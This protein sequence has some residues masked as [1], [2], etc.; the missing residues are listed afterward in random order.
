MQTSPSAP[1]GKVGYNR[2]LLLVAGLGGLLY[3]VD[4]GI[5]SGALPYLEA[6]S[7]FNQG[8]LSFVV[9]AVLL[10]SVISTLFAGVL[11][12]WMGRKR[13][14]AL[15]GLLFVVSIPMIALAHGYEPLVLGRLLQ[16]ISAGFI[17]VVVPLYL[18]EC[19]GAADR[20]KGTGIFQWLLTLG[21]VAAAVVGFYF[22]YRLEHVAQ[23]GDAAKIFAFKDAAWRQIFW[24]SLPPGLLFVIGSFMVSESP[25]WLY[26]RGRH[27]AARAA[28]LRSRSAA[29]AE[30]EFQEMAATVQAEAAS[31]GQAGK[32][33][34]SIFRRKYVIPFVLACIILA[35]NQAT[36][37]NSIIGYNA[38]ILLQSGLSDFHAHLGYVGLTLVNFL[39][40]IGAVVLVD[41]KG[42]KFLLSVGS[43]GIIASLIAVGTLFHRTEA[44]RVDCSP[45]VQ[46]LVQPDQTAKIAFSATTAQQLLAHAGPAGQALAS[47]PV[48]LIVIYSYGD[49]RAATTVVRSDDATARPVEINRGSCVPANKVVAFFSNPFADLTAA[50]TAPLKI[51]NALITPVPSARNGWITA[52]CIFAFMAFFAVGPG[53]CVWLALSELMPTRI[54][55]NGMSIALLINQAVSTVIAAVFLP[56]VGKYGYSTMFFIFAGCTVVYFVTAM[57]FLPETKGK[58]LEEIEAHFER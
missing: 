31:T 56:T 10:G 28:L 5:I 25:R 29:Q 42:R 51:E 2:F 53:V 4:V 40:T 27:E 44:Q 3:G 58:T 36:G 23:S 9:A 18:A 22:S 13:L 57:F 1:S 8:Q 54:R 6:T 46:A 16:G 15:S 55:S 49:F 39:V 26:R 12:D 20:G 45:A 17:G 34:D 35:C 24:V 37:V 32:P 7:G 50:R 43:A 30:V 33:R 21:I 41:R 19:L 14:M 48:S 47:R 11:A 52:V 38:T